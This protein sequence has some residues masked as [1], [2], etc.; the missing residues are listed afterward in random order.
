MSGLRSTVG[1]FSA[2][3]DLLNIQAYELLYRFWRLVRHLGEPRNHMQ[4][5]LDQASLFRATQ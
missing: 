4:V 2:T 1:L 3:Q 5:R